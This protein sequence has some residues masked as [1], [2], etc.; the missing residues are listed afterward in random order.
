MLSGVAAGKA[1]AQGSVCLVNHVSRSVYALETY[2]LLQ[3]TTLS[4]EL[5]NKLVPVS[6][7]K[8]WSAMA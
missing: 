5:W 8:R 7:L 2:Q 4:Q 6:L 1:A 3:I